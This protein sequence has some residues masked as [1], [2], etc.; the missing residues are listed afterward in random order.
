MTTTT[1]KTTRR[2][3]DEL[4]EQTSISK[5]LLSD[6]LMGCNIE[7]IKSFVQENN[8]YVFISRHGLNK[9]DIET[10]NTVK[11]NFDK[12]FTNST[13]PQV[14]SNIELMDRT[15]KH[16][17]HPHAMLDSCSYNN[18]GWEYCEQ[19]SVHYIDIDTASV[20]GGCFHGVD[21]SNLEYIGQT[22]RTVW[23]WGHAGACGNG[24]IYITVKVNNFRLVTDRRFIP[25]T[26]SYTDEHDSGYKFF[27][28]K[29]DT[30]STAL[31]SA[32]KTTKGLR[33]WLKERNL[34]IGKKIGWWGT[35]H[36]LIGDFDEHSCMSLEE[37]KDNMPVDVKEFL[38]TS[39][40]RVTKAYMNGTTLYYCNSNVKDRYEE[41]RILYY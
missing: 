21:S 23:T 29:R 6:D 28:S 4:A 22:Q 1:I 2:Q 5:H 33:T 32:F 12:A 35:T 38:K 30:K 24:G 26:I 16:C 40:G 18:T 8:N 14:Y 15:N 10:Y 19:P 34:K 25:W 7:D 17:F 31:E 36:E 11:A 39:N 37:Y 9:A 13:M 41:N 20:S 3:L 27:V